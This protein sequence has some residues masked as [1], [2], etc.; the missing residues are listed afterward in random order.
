M[1]TRNNPPDRLDKLIEYYV[2]TG[3]LNNKGVLTELFQDILHLEGHH[4][5]VSQTMLEQDEFSSEQIS[6]RY[7]HN[8]FNKQIS[9]ADKEELGEMSEEIHRIDLRLRK[10]NI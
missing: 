10:F 1:T 8:F 3:S 4:W 7:D 6:S 2:R 5:D 9:E